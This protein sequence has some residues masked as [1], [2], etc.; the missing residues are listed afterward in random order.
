M[1]RDPFFL[2][3]TGTTVRERESEKAK[4]RQ[5]DEYRIRKGKEKRPS[6]N[7]TSGVSIHHFALWLLRS[8]SPALTGFFFP[9]ATGGRK[10]L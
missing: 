9:H 1:N 7:P 4:N 2:K 10:R 3:D 6:S 8:G 5:G